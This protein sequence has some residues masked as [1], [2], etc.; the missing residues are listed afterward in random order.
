MTS[1][2]TNHPA[3]RA[4][5][6]AG[7]ENFFRHLDKNSFPLHIFDKYFYTLVK[8]LYTFTKA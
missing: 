2:P 7:D 1:V 5:G 8:K 4:Q 3:A 6:V